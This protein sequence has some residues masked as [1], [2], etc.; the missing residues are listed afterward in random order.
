[1][2][3]I[4]HITNGDLWPSR[5]ALIKKLLK[6]PL[7]LLFIGGG[8]LHFTATPTYERL[9]PPYIPYHLQLVYLSGVI[10]SALGLL[11]L[12]PKSQRVAAWALI[13]TL[14]AIFP[15]NVH[16]ALTAGTD[17]PAMPGVSTELAW[18]RLPLQF[19]LIAWAYWYT[20]QDAL[21]MRGTA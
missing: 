18:L 1:M 7:A 9:M 8:V 19:L 20:R 11:L 21:V 6:W 17:H 14:L 15:A 5:K 13:P 10:E 3:S 2:R 16:G 4:S 12:L